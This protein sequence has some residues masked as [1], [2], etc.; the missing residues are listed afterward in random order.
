V[1]VPPDVHKHNALASYTDELQHMY[2]CLYVCVCKYIYIYI[3]ICMYVCILVTSV[4]E[5]I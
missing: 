5:D 2:V 4:S 3:Y 1:Q